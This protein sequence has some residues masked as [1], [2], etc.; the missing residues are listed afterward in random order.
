MASNEDS[1]NQRRP[2]P[3]WWNSSSE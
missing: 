2:W 3:D 1:L